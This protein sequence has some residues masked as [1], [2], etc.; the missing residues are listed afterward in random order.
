MTTNEPVEFYEARS[1]YT[2][3]LRE[4]LRSSVS[5]VIVDDEP[6][7]YP[8]LIAETVDSG[9]CKMALTAPFSDKTL[10]LL[11]GDAV[12]FGDV[13]HTVPVKLPNLSH[14]VLIL[15]MR[16]EARQLFTGFD[17][18]RFEVAGIQ[19]LKQLKGFPG[20]VFF[21]TRYGREWIDKEGLRFYG[22]VPLQVK[23]GPGGG[24]L[25]QQ[26]REAIKTTI[27]QAL[28][29]CPLAEVNSIEL[30]GK[31]CRIVWGGEIIL[32][33]NSVETRILY[34]LLRAA[35]SGMPD[36][37]L[38]KLVGYKPRPRKKGVRYL[39]PVVVAPDGQM[40][41]GEEPEIITAEER[42][43]ART[44]YS[45]D[46]EA[47]DG[48]RA[49]L[50]QAEKE[51][52]NIGNQQL[53]LVATAF[54][55]LGQSQKVEPTNVRK[56]WDAVRDGLNQICEDAQA[57][58]PTA[59]ADRDEAD[60]LLSQMVDLDEKLTLAVQRVGELKDE[61]TQASHQCS[62][63]YRKG[64][65]SYPDGHGNFIV[66]R[67]ASPHAVYIA[68][69]VPSRAAENDGRIVTALI[70][71]KQAPPAT[72]IEHL[73]KSLVRVDGVN[74]YTGGEQWIVR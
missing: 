1:K 36:T 66:P 12:T 55:L 37:E 2:Y 58:D 8:S 31:F 25:G 51:V 41:D 73:R 61:F 26:D 57:G 20:R 60:A 7:P 39:L 46:R 30:D 74:R 64:W 49:K 13:D 18:S 71:L 11:R 35:P 62:D 63:T 10:S 17:E 9:Q 67:T 50:E 6:G 54:E 47:R 28:T 5:C 15:D 4:A 56:H 38:C 59:A 24:S 33:K 27:G 23:A 52:R 34:Q 29:H 53:K 14:C 16:N 70:R 44:V 48:A 19:F 3:Y 68:K 22:V 72:F 40:P 21:A 42:K 65:R 32:L 69:Y 43:H 45:L